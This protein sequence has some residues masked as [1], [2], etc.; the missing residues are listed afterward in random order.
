MK[1]QWQV[2]INTYQL[3]LGTSI[4]NGNGL[5]AFASGHFERGS[6]FRST[7]AMGGVTYIPDIR[8]ARRGSDSHEE[9][10]ETNSDASKRQDFQLDVTQE[11][12]IY[13]WR[14][15]S[16]YP[17]NAAF[18]RGSGYQIYA[19][20][21]F[22]MKG[23]FGPDISLD[24]SVKL[25]PVRSSQTSPSYAG[26]YSG[27]SDTIVSTTASY[28]ADS[29]PKPYVT[30]DVNMPTGKTFLRQSLSRARMDP[31][32]VELDGFGKGF[33]VG[34][35]LGSIF[36]LSDEW[37][38][39]LSMS[40]MHSG[41]YS[42]DG[43]IVVATGDQPTVHYQPGGALK[44]TGALA[45]SRAPFDATLKATLTRSSVSYSDGLPSV[46]SGDSLNVTAEV[47]T[48]LSDEYALTVSTNYTFSKPNKILDPKLNE[49]MQEASNA[50]SSLYRSE[51]FLAYKWDAWSAGPVASVTYRNKNQFDP[52]TYN[53]VPAKAMGAVG[54]R[55]KR[56]HD[57]NTVFNLD[58]QYFKSRENKSPAKI[59]DGIM[60]QDSELPVLHHSG[61]KVMSSIMRK[62]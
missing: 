35:T 57:E 24:S 38:I 26:T 14:G 21:T 39:D 32:Y 55:L 41:A 34:A 36:A 11:F 22:R 13:S 45:F 10:S 29:G 58:V 4:S 20:S 8:R 52:R 53:F 51:A 17:A 54:F 28:V 60:V 7:S 59:S 25:G 46:R 62:F 61:L 3:A 9:I 33:D 12:N 16:S 44:A 19:P 47:T 27:L 40:H 50:N 43:P 42:V 56:A 49:F 31:D 37:S 5:S 23:S 2:N 6:S 18:K 48:A 30:V 15:S 1:S